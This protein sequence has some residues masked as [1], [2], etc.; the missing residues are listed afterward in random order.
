MMIA[1]PSSTQV[2]DSK[3][4]LAAMEHS[5][6]M[7]QFGTDGTVLWANDNFARAIGYRAEELPGMSHK[8][9]C[10]EAFAGSAEYG[11]LW[12]NLREGV[13]F[14]E[15]IQRVTKEGRIIWLEATYMPVVRYG[16]VEAVLK[17]GTDITARQESEIAQLA[18]EL[19][20]LAECLRTRADDGIGKSREVAAAIRRIVEAAGD[21]SRLFADLQ[22][23]TDTIKGVVQAIREIASQTQLLSLNAAIEAAHAG[24]FGL[25]FAVVAQEVRKLSEQVREATKQVQYGV[26]EIVAATTGIHAGAGRL[27]AAVSDSARL[28]EQALL[29][30]EGIGGAAQD[31]DAKARSLTDCM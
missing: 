4:V 7:I 6:A 30:F 19:R 17:V 11:R 3:S 10:T 20:R 8:Q 29:E 2:L 5:L 23:Q 27:D 1:A 18:M 26:K 13:S 25:G 9:F 21:N 22:K 31:L 28:I 15:K 12:S 24:E 14:Q 16:A